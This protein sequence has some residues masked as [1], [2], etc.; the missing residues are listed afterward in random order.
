MGGGSG[1]YGSDL[2]D[3]P[4]VGWDAM[5]LRVAQGTELTFGLG[6]RQAPVDSE[7]REEV[8]LVN[9]TKHRQW[10]RF[11]PAS[12]PKCTLSAEPPEG[13]VGPCSEARVVVSAT[14]HCTTRLRIEL[15]LVVW[16]RTKS[17]ANNNGEGRQ[18]KQKQR[19]RQPV[20]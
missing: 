19:Q 8:T 17:S 12:G 18:Q 3:V 6:T 9:K 16:R 13:C 7:L 15:P 4:V 11:H 1:D 2:S 5:P 20:F 10:F 14:I